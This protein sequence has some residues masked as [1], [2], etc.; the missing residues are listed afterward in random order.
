VDS[1]ASR[2]LIWKVC[3]WGKA[4]GRSMLD[5]GGINYTDA[6]K[7]GIREFKQSFGGIEVDIGIYRYA[8]RL[9][10]ALKRG[11]TLFNK[12]IH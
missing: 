12:N 6:S 7:A 9:F 5:L 2:A 3:K 1:Y 8:T 10:L 4:H 11:L